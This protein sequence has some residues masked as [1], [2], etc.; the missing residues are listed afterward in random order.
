LPPVHDRDVTLIYGVVASLV[1]ITK[2]DVLRTSVA[3]SAGE[4][5]VTVGAVTSTDNGTDTPP[6]A[7]ALHKL[8]DKGVDAAETMS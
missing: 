4:N 2:F 5:V 7:P 6:H 8:P 3:P 1:V